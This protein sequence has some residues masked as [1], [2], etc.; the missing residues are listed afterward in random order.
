MA[1]ETV[2]GPTVPCPCGKGSAT[3]SRVEHDTFPGK[4]GEWEGPAIECE[5]CKG[6]YVVKEAGYKC[7]YYI[8]VEKADK[9]EWKTLY[10]GDHDFMKV[11]PPDW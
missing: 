9:V 7:R 3:Y 4:P 5:E 6:K 1:Y 10:D 11:K 2:F 8:P